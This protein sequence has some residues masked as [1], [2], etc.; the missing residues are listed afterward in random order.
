MN[1]CNVIATKKCSELAH[2]VAFAPPKMNF[3]ELGIPM[4]IIGLQKQ[5]TGS[6]HH[7]N[8]FK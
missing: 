3:E 1:N 2:F 4:R 7:L 8:R 6:I 5:G